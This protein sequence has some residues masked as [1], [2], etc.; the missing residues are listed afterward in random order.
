MES[1]VRA[2]RIESSATGTHVPIWID[3][4]H[5]TAEALL[6]SRSGIT[7]EAIHRLPEPEQSRLWDLRPR[8]PGRPGAAWDE[9]VPSLTQQVHVTIDRGTLEYDRRDVLEVWIC[10][11]GPLMITWARPFSNDCYHIS[12]SPPNAL[13]H[14]QAQTPRSVRIAFASGCVVNSSLVPLGLS[15]QASGQ[16]G[17]H[18]RNYEPEFLTRDGVAWT[19]T[20]L[21]ALAPEGLRELMTRNPDLNQWYL[22]NKVF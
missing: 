11:D 13:S 6:D 7:V 14:V 17:L 12:L 20:A 21:G 10:D 22:R 15:V 16:C 5:Q 9:D 19:D 4:E 8:P 3:A 1:R 2:S 18:E